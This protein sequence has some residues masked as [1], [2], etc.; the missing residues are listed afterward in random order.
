MIAEKTTAPS[1]KEKQV[2][3]LRKVLTYAYEEGIIQQ[4]PFANLKFQ[5]KI[6][7]ELL[8]QRQNTKTAQNNEGTIK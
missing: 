8:S 2:I 5:G 1:T 4:L 6:I 3:T 7:Q